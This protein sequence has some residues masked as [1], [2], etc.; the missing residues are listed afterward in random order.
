MPIGVRIVGSLL[1]VVGALV[2]LAGVIGNVQ[3]PGD[4]VRA[5]LFALAM[6]GCSALSLVVL[7]ARGAKSVK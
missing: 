2:S 7:F 4:M 6:L 5:G 1:F 3:G